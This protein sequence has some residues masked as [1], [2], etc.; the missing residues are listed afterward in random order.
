MSLP[1]I[2]SHRS[3]NLNDHEGMPAR[4]LRVLL[5]NDHLGYAQ[6]MIHGVICY[7][8]TLAGRFD[9]RTARLACF[10]SLR[11]AADSWRARP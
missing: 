9:S 5:V 10:R 7:F 8:M 11:M 4:L 2:T 3:G 1:T 6:D